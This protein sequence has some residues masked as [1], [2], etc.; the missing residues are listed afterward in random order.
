MRFA[1]FFVLC[2]AVAPLSATELPAFDFTPV[3]SGLARPT[4]VV[5]D[6]AGRL[7]ILEQAGR[8][9][10]V[11]D[12]KAELFLDLT[13]RVD[14]KAN[15]CGLLGLAFHPNFRSNG[16]FFLNYTTSSRGKLETVV[17]EFRAPAGAL[18]VSRENE[19]EVLRFEQP[20]G[21]HN[22]GEVI[23]GPDGKLYIGVGD[24]GAGGDPNNNGQNLGT[25]LGKILRIDVDARSP[26]AVPA[27]NP[28]VHTEGARPEI[29]AYGLRNPWRFSFDR[30][31]GQLFCGDVGQNK[32]EE[33]DIIEKGKNYGWRLREGFHPFKE[34]NPNLMTVAPI[35]E[36][37]RELG[38]SVTG[39]YVYRGKQIPGLEGVYLYADYVSGRI[40]GLKWD[41]QRLTFDRELR[42]TNLMISSFGE[43][44]QGE[45][46]ICDHVA[47]RLLKL[48]P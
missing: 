13:D 39:G 3:V 47:G 8:M 2:F 18:S 26:Y 37:G 7:F 48:V 24:G 43:D 42:K 44:S 4:C 6:G 9:L 40:W 36:Y 23:F 31:T 30:Q 27:D 12:G 41:G 21:N 10:R 16:R 29:W 38:M 33:I 28:F 1:L 25:W 14:S 20:F 46:Y 45:L 22:G 15:E 35:K 5:E 11:V 32:Y 19:R 34:E 17:A